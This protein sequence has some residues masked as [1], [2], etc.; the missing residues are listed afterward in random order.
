[1]EAKT[2]EERLAPPDKRTREVPGLA[3]ELPTV[4]NE[5]LA[6]RA[7][8]P[9]PVENLKTEPM[10]GA[11]GREAVTAAGKAS[12]TPV[13]AAQPPAARAPACPRARTRA[14]ACARARTRARARA[15]ARARIRA[16]ARARAHSR[17]RSLARAP[18]R[19][20]PRARARPGSRPQPPPR[21]AHDAA[22]PAE[23]P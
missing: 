20:R 17:S 15:R 10:P 18:S 8:A 2:R 21:A 19:P 12:Q 14:R 11:P 7:D 6:P 16:R 1:R 13:A 23:P 4:K 3:S 22:R 9:K 5:V